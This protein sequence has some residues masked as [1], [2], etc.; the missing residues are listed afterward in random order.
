MLIHIP[1]RDERELFK[2]S[3]Y[4]LLSHIANAGNFVLSKI[5]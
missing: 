1:K 5:E 2:A 3:K 4:H